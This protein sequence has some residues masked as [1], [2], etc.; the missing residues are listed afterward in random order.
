MWA[1]NTINNKEREGTVLKQDRTE[2]VTAQSINL[3][4]SR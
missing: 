4:I 2:Q 1:D 3:D